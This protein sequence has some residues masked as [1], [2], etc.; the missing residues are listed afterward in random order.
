MEFSFIMPHFSFAIASM[1]FPSLSVWSTYRSDTCC[2]RLK[3]ICGIKPAAHTDFYHGDIHFLYAE[4]EERESR[5]D[6]KKKGG[7]NLDDLEKL[8]KNFFILVTRAVTSASS[9]FLSSGNDI[10]IR[11]LKSTRWG[12]V[13]RPAF[14]PPSFRSNIQTHRSNPCLSFR[15]CVST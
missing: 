10:L 1:V 8:S 7:P 6:F 5:I 2:Q 11:S 4:E 13:Y 14:I 3:R 9:I 15:L 12:E